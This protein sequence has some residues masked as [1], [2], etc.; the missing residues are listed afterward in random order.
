MAERI[1]RLAEG[2][3]VIKNVNKYTEISISKCSKFNR[4]G[5]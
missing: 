2:N 5:L 4:S 3:F 1:L